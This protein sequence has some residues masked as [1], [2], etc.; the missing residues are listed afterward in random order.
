MEN[1]AS[2]IQILNYSEKE[3]MSLNKFMTSLSDEIISFE[4]LEKILNYL[5][6]NGIKIT[7]P[8]Q[9]KIFACTYDEIFKIVEAYK[10]M[11][12]LNALVED[13][14]RITC[15]NSLK[16]IKY[17]RL[18]E[19]PLTKPNG[20]FNKSIFSKTLFEKEYGAIDLDK[21]LAPKE[22]DPLEANEYKQ[23]A[24]QE[25]TNL[26]SDNKELDEYEAVL[27]SPQVPADDDAIKLFD[28]LYNIS[29]KV[30]N[31]LY[32]NDNSKVSVPDN[33][34]TNLLKLTAQKM[35]D[36]NKILLYSLTY[37][38]HLNSEEEQ[39]IKNKIDEQLSN[40]LDIDN[41]ELE[42]L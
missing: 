19:L 2:K 17:L 15:A 33:V 38:K 13:P 34:C 20:K 25:I 21:E 39:F 11:S 26:F 16:R 29:E 5:K 36:E 31:E 22:F 28:K 3:L 4:E 7:K 41:I 6:A 32:G 10:E 18:K 1:F 37:G 24:F 40:T 9:N 35:E 27:N 23:D 42:N 30:L 8:S 14:T 12:L